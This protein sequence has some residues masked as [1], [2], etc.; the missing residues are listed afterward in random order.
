[1][2]LR[3]KEAG[4][5]GDK[6]QGRTLRSL[7]LPGRAH[8]PA[9][10]AAIGAG[11]SSK[12]QGATEAGVPAR[13]DPPRAPRLP[14]AAPRGRARG[15]QVR[16]AAYPGDDGGVP[17]GW[18]EQ[19]RRQQQQEQQRGAVRAPHGALGTGGSW[20]RLGAR[21]GGLAGCCREPP[22]GYKGERRRD[23][24]P[25]PPGSPRG[26]HC[27]GTPP[28]PTRTRA[29]TRPAGFRDDKCSRSAPRAPAPG[30]TQ[31]APPARRPAPRA[32]LRASLAAA[33]FRTRRNRLCRLRHTRLLS[34]FPKLHVPSA[35]NLQLIC[36]TDVQG[37]PTTC[38]AADTSGGGG[39]RSL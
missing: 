27:A 35:G 23:S 13:K 4:K 33:A 38:Q 5:G 11:H 1:M 10:S 26:G 6:G 30:A 32:I 14:S 7:F 8:C 39:D 31:A 29:P 25:R 9:P 34:W 2:G 20:R 12:C 17:G 18:R 3:E 37:A 22:G 15:R 16:P 24:R 36:S 28:R 19:Q 21:S